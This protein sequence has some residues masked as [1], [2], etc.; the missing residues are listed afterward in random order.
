MLLS[1]LLLLVLLVLVLWL[2][3]GRWIEDGKIIRLL[4]DFTVHLVVNA[5][6]FQGPTHDVEG[7]GRLLLCSL[8]WRRNAKS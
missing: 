7:K 5:G 3:Y 2:D 6:I 4:D 8:H 1:L